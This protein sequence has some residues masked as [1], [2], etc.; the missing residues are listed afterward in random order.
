MQGLGYHLLRAGCQRLSG[1]GLLA[2]SALTSLTTVKLQHSHSLQRTHIEVCRLSGS[3][4]FLIRVT[5]NYCSQCASYAWLAKQYSHD[6][7]WCGFMMLW[8]MLH[9]TQNV[10]VQRMQHAP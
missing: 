2:V 8:T 9:A 3:C 1:A 4:G 5:S 6:P 10:Q 7:L